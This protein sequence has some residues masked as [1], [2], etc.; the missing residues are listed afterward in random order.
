M[1]PKAVLFDLYG[2]LAS[3]EEPVTDKRAAEFL[4]SRNSRFTHRHSQL[5]YEPSF[6]TEQINYPQKPSKKLMRMLRT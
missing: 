5:P 4:V 3:G 6:W 2:T 1:Y